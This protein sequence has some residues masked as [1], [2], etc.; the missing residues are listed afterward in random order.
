MKGIS[1][2]ATVASNIFSDTNLTFTDTRAYGETEFSI[3]CSTDSLWCIATWPKGGKIAFR[4][5]YAPDGGIELRDSKVDGSTVTYHLNS[6][7]GSYKVTVSFPNLATGGV[8]H[9]QTKLTPKTDLLIPYWPRDIVIPGKDGK[10]ENTAGKIHMSQ[11]G[12]RS[13][14]VFFSMTRPKAGSVLYLQNLTALADY[15]QQTETSAGNVVG[16]NWPEL[17]FALPPSTD[18]PLAEGKEVILSDAFIAFNPD[19]PDGEPTMVRLFLDTLALV[20]LQLPKPGTEYHNWPEILDLGLRD[21]LHSP[22]CWSQAD[23]HH[24]FNAYVSD[25]TTPPEI[26][27][28]LA[29]L[30]P[31]TDYVEWSGK[32]LDA[33]K[34]IKDGL[35]AFYDDKLKTIMRWLPANV[36]QLEGEE[37]QKKPLVMDSWYLHHPLLN[38]SRLALTGDKEAERLFM[39]SIDYAIKVAHHFKYQW[40]VFYKMDTLEVLK[41]ETEPGKGGEKDVPGL[42]CHVMLQAYELTKD[43]K[44]LR[45]AETAAKKLQGLGF[46]LFY[47]ANNTSFGAGALLRLYKITKDKTYLDISYLCIA[48]VLRNVQL[49]DCNY[50]NGKFFSSFFAMFPLQN[51]PYTAVYEEQEV[52]CALH[53]FLRHAED[54]EELL[55]SIRLL[56]AEYIRYLVSRA[57]YYYPPMLPKEVLADKPKIGELTP[58]LWIALE[59]MQDGWEKCG[60]VGQ[61]VYGAGNAF[62]ILPRHYMRVKDEDFMICVDYPTSGFSPVKK[63]PV[64]FTVLGDKRLTC[65]LM[66][67]KGEKKLPKLSVA[68]KGK[69]H[70]FEGK[71]TKDGNIEYQIPG[72][73]SLKISW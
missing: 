11:E 24:Y 26:M 13:G 6:L 9:Y 10:P 67:I 41:P 45:E 48:N 19:V 58:H 42:Y 32:T 18:K 37:E 65:R 30:L 56:L 4:M 36:D 2:W 53:D 52:F 47:Q 31:L 3:Y 8:L 39:G 49:W 69:K 21:L 1:P 27:V 64:S 72:N 16:G 28:Q 14:M 46:E 50:G 63:N 15:C 23:G 38:L 66:I 55:P 35:P 33:I 60:Q 25:Y 20:Y 68:I 51:A 29:V 7:I 71:P 12:T 73:T 40:P 70:V 22:G 34:I 57:V 43:K 5:A 44:Y 61:E 62:G 59:D 17:G 54:V